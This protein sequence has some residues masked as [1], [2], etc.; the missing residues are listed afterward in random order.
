MD[1][2]PNKNAPTIQKVSPKGFTLIEL[3]M[4][5]AIIGIIAAVSL[6][7][8]S[9]WIQKQRLKNAGA[10]MQHALLEARSKAIGQNATVILALDTPSANQ[11]TVFVDNG[12]FIFSAADTTVLQ[13]SL[14]SNIAISST[15]TDDQA[16]YNALGLPVSP[17]SIT[18]THASS[19]MQQQVILG[20]SGSVRVN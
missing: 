10:S 14:A 8:F 13:K 9:L 11:F 5:V 3:M 15:F 20:A 16:C 12:D 7:Q 19:T 4:V 1:A 17:G 18:L 2:Q 6:P